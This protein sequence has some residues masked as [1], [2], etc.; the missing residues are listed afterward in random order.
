MR[1]IRRKPNVMK[2][3]FVS[4]S[5]EDKKS[6]AGVVGVLRACGFEVLYSDG[7]VY[8]SDGYI[9]Q[10]R[11]P[12]H[13]VDSFVA[14]MSTHFASSKK[15]LAEREIALYLSQKY[16]WNDFIHVAQIGQIYFSQV[17][18]LG[19]YDWFNFVGDDPINEMAQL[20]DTLNGVFYKESKID[21]PPHINRQELENLHVFLCHSSRDKFFVRKLYNRLLSIGI[22]PWFDEESLLPGQDWDLVIQEEVKKSDAIIVCLSHNSVNQKGYVQKEI[23]LA[24]DEADKQPENTI[25]IIP[26]KLENCDIPVRL[27]HLHCVN[28][29]EYFEKGLSKLLISLYEC[30]QK[31][32]Q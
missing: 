6:A 28:L 18:F 32:M 22:T 15:C 11:S 14:L 16:L 27:D 31:K 23:R 1:G 7:L 26:A 13:H 21:I 24:L 19:N 2:K 10:N 3:I 25:F 29:Y 12:I 4:Y 30:A 20:I 8:R 17:G 9:D 5:E